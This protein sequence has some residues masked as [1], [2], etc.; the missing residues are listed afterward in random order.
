MNQPTQKTFLRALRGEIVTP[1]PVW[2]M[3]QA[4]RYLPEYRQTRAT[5]GSFLDLC[6]TPEFAVEATLQPL[7]RYNFDAAILFSDILVVP[8]A[9]GQS[10]AFKTG[11]GP[12]LTALENEADLERLCL[13]GFH[14]HL[15][16]VYE[17]LRR[18]RQEIPA[19]TS[20]IGFSGA[21]WTL[22]TYMVEGKGSKDY[23]LTKEWAYART[24]LFTR[25]IDLLVESISTY[26][27]RQADNGAEALQI[28]DSWA[29]V[30]PEEEFHRWVT[31]PI[32]RI[33]ANV[34]ALHPTVPIIGFPRGAGMYYER[35]AKDTKVD[36]LGLDTT[37]PLDWAARVLQPICTLQGNLDPILVVA[38][39]ERMD[40]AVDHI[41]NVLGHGPFVFNLGH[42][43]VPHT[44]PEN[45]SR[46]VER[47]RRFQG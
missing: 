18:L 17:I 1:P 21:P 47:V 33:V 9:L 8:H 10:V 2:L 20:L 30:L 32:A 41:L 46:L 14:A 29:G 7:R 43:I 3:R 40:A 37:V 25:L 5:A 26:L 39:G 35:F 34:K 6:Y 42:G 12:V 27:I 24:P 23:A 15:A 45:V 19:T 13:D 31:E 11:E 36:A 22:A 38:G 28:F 4:G 16:P 44:P